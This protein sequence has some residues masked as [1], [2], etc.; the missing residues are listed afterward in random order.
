M[1]V[2]DLERPREAG[3][4]DIAG[5][6]QRYRGVGRLARSWKE[7]LGIDAL[8]YA[9]GPPG[10]V[11]IAL[12]KRPQQTRIATRGGDL[13]WAW[14]PRPGQAPHL[15]RGLLPG[16]RS[17][18]VM[19]EPAATDIGARHHAGAEFYRTRKV[20]DKTSAAKKSK[21]VQL[22]QTIRTKTLGPACARVGLY[23]RKNSAIPHRSRVAESE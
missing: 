3:A 8:T 6:A 4:L 18:E 23:R 12:L 15:P 20:G 10:Q 5:T 21:M 11:F 22:M 17:R 19:A 14:H 2:A 1:A 9:S 7:H 13:M 16:H